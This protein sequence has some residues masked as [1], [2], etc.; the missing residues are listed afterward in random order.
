M[1]EFPG[2]HDPIIPVT[3]KFRTKTKSE[4]TIQTQSTN[5]PMR[6][7]TSRADFDTWSPIASFKEL[8]L[9]LAYTAWRKCRI[10]HLDFIGVFLYAIA[11]SRVF[12][13]LP[14][15]WRELFPELADW[16]GV[17][18]RLLESIYGSIDSS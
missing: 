10:Y 15:E 1:K 2:P 4:G 14:K 11:C 16:F 5:M 9:F 3:V 7:Q 8:K 13:I 17:L 6:R 12:T 18:L